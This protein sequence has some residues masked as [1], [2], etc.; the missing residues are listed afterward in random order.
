QV[1]HHPRDLLFHRADAR[2]EPPMQAEGVALGAS[3]GR[4]LVQ[5]GIVQGVYAGRQGTHGHGD[6]SRFAVAA[7]APS[8]PRAGRGSSEATERWMSSVASAPAWLASCFH[9]VDG[10]ATA[11]DG[12]GQ[13]GTFHEAIRDQPAR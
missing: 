8:M 5:G 9:L 7:A 4:S 2:R 10:L 12:A 6:L 11:R 3:E 1:L 13:E